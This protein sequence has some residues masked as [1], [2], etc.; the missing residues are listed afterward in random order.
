MSETILALYDTLESA[1]NA[2]SDLVNEGFNRSDIG[3]VVNNAE[4]LHTTATN[5][6]DVKA[7][8][9]A[10][11]GLLAGGITGLVVGLTAITIPGIGPI[12]AAGPLA[13]ALG[14]ATG[15]G[16]GA[17]AGAVTGGLAASLIDL[18][19][20]ESQVDYYGEAV[21]RGSAMVSVIAEDTRVIEAMRVLN[22]HNP[23]D[24]EHRA[25]QWGQEGWKG[26]AESDLTESTEV[27]ARRYSPNTPR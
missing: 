14:G 24:I 1:N 6:D 11:L 12:V 8:E 25:R 20:P 17:V 10:G 21:R 22:R 23:Y 3:L 7:D 4:D 9:G 26:Y 2:I 5:R 18:G 27:H 15:A 16:V 13:M 19:V